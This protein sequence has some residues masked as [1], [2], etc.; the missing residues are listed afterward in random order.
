MGSLIS[1]DILIQCLCT[2]YSL[3]ISLKRYKSQEMSTW[4]YNRHLLEDLV[5]IWM[6]SSKLLFDLEFKIDNKFLLY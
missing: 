6:G 1:V 4:L 3:Q 2:T 5:D